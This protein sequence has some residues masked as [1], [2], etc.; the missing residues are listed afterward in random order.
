MAT[1]VL[2]HSQLSGLGSLSTRQLQCHRGLVFTNADDGVADH[3]NAK[4][5]ISVAKHGSAE[6]EHEAAIEMHHDTNSVVQVDVKGDLTVDGTLTYASVQ[7]TGGSTF[8]GGITVSGGDATV[9]N[10]VT[11]GS[12]DV[13]GVSDFT[14]IDW[15]SLTSAGDIITTGT[16]AGSNGSV[17]A[18]NGLFSFVSTD[19]ADIRSGRN[20]QAAQHV[21]LTGGSDTYLNAANAYARFE[22]ATCRSG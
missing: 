20:L 9:A 8:S 15:D 19:T 13:T 1:A 12:L 4:A 14:H 2:S 18:H 16:L 5:Q 11:A 3:A 22:T 21:L 17:R 7:A 6:L 10:K